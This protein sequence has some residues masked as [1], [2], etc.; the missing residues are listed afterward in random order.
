MIIYIIVASI[1]ILI[2]LFI[3]LESMRENKMLEINEYDIISRKLPENEK[4]I[5]AL[6]ISDF[7]NMDFG[8]G[9][10]KI[11]EMV[12]GVK[13]DFILLGGDM[14][15][16][17]P[18]AGFSHAVK[19][20]NKLAEKY[21]VYYGIGNHE[22]RVK[23][24][25]EKYG[26]MWDRYFKLL[27]R[28]IVFL[29]D[30]KT[31][32]KYKNKKINI[33]SLDIGKEYYKRFFI[34]D[35][36]KNYIDDKLGKPEKQAF[37]ILLAHNPDYF[38]VYADW[39]ADLTLSGHVH[40]GIIRLPLFGGVLSP[41]LTLFPKYDKGEFIKEDKKMIV[42]GGIGQHSIKIRFNSV[43]EIILINLLNN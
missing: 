14:I 22:M 35:M 42:S 16:G 18:D 38:P 19:F 13:P 5:R 28:R 25:R 27:D 10:K 17:K 7:H 30:E 15:L 3:I 6:F 29:K 11:H 24:N 43:P 40:G 41:R 12:D 37:N 23:D 33:Y 8:E 39:G 36:K 31:E 26:D 20:I 21:P 4:G 1:L 2:L 9:N 34:G 32:L